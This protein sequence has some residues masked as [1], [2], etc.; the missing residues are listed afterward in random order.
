MKN[1]KLNH[2]L[3]W[4]ISI[5][6][7]FAMNSCRA[8]KKE[9]KRSSETTNTIATDKSVVVEKNDSNV[10]TEVKTTVDDKNK[11]KTVET[12]YKPIDASK[13]ASVTTPDG[14]QHKLN[15]AEIRTK[16]TVQDNN[17]KTDWYVNSEETNKSSLSE[18]KDTKSKDTAKKKEEVI[19][20]DK[21]AY[22]PFNLVWLLV[23]VLCIIFFLY[24]KYKDKLWWI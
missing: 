19:D 15:N 20:I 8:V 9:E 22:Y 10:K 18:S 5:A 23:P 1:K 14:K 13:E 6:L 12:I 21:K 17:T 3:L 2:L 4:V 7:A 24:N 11:I 16:E